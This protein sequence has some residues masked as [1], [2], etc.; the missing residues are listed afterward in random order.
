[1]L[2]TFTAHE[3]SELCRFAQAAYRADRNDIG[4]LCSGVN[5]GCQVATERYDRMMSAYREWLV[6]GTF[7]DL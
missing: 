1:M 5:A 4:H 6:F 2:M 7:S 3:A